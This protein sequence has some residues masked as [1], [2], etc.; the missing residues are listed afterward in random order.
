MLHFEKGESSSETSAAA[1]QES[2]TLSSCCVNVKNDGVL[3]TASVLVANS[4]KQLK[5]ARIV[6]DNGSQIGLITEKLCD[7]LNLQKIPIDVT[8][9]VVNNL[10]SSVKYRCNVQIL[11]RQ[12]NFEFKLPCLVVPEITTHCPNSKISTIAAKIPSHLNLADPEFDKAGKIDILIG[13]NIFWTLIC[14]GQVKLNG[15][16]L[17]LQKTR[18]ELEEHLDKKSK[19]IDENLCESLFSK[20]VKRDANGRFIVTI[21][22][23]GNLD[24][25]GESKE[26]AERCFL[27]LERKLERKPELKKEYTA[28][29]TEYEKL[30]HISK[31]LDESYSPVSYY[32]PHHC[33]V[34]NDSLSTRVRVVFDASAPTASGVSLNDLQMVGPLLQDDLFSILIRFRKHAYFLGADIEKM[35]R[36]VLVTPEQRPLQRILWR[37]DPNQT[38]KR[39]LKWLAHSDHLTYSVT[40]S[41]NNKITKRQILSDISLIFDPLGLLG[42]CIILAQIQLQKLW[43]EKLSWD[44]SLLAEVHSQWT[45]YRNQLPTLNSIK[46]PRH[47][48]CSSAVNI[49]LHGFSDVALNAYG[50][51][52]YL[53]SED[54]E[55]NVCIQLICSKSRVAPLKTQTIARLE[56]CGALE[57]AKLVSK[58]KTALDLSV[59]DIYYWS[60]STIVLFWLR[61]QSKT[62]ETFIANRVGRIQE[63][64]DIEFWKHVRSEDNPADCISRGI[65]PSLLE[66]AKLW[67]KGPPFLFKDKSDWPSMPSLSHDVPG[68]RKR[69]NIAVK[70]ENVDF[71][72]FERYQSLPQLIRVIAYCKR[73][74]NNCK[75]KENKLSGHLRSFEL[76]ESKIALA[77]LSQRNS[78]PEEIKMLSRMTPITK[79]KLASL[80]PFLDDRGILKVGGSMLVLNYFFSSIREHFWPLGGGNLARKVVRNCVM[81]FR[82]NPRGST[83]MMGNLP[84]QRV[85]PSPPFYTTGVD[86]AGPFLK[87]IEK[88]EALRLANVT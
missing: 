65:A 85:S 39:S 1:P 26:Q 18:L 4:D 10:S 87:G 45:E 48:I 51:C 11:S 58:V 40:V 2:K 61:T 63:L 24:Q 55:G 23:K 8:L 88:V 73:F 36:Q 38:S 57:L 52:V 84:K 33:V 22:L 6:L 30:G 43:L 67:W 46:V 44:E 13:N 50:A 21:P 79:G 3:S 31:E 9:S 28:F 5:T 7:S 82:V 27:N 25:L 74:S 75:P 29:M 68:L 17:L 64:T 15:Q 16:S 14:I 70:V 47:I 59:D 42:P 83:P 78:F 72:I 69:C 32:M 80:N 54:K 12:N 77:K 86:N 62:L 76:A 37:P 49:Q 19:S 41:D 53:R 71:S 35:Y 56:L 81:C 66:G 20:T 34:R 60:V